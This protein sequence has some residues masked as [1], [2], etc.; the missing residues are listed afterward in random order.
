[1]IY[2]L[3]KRQFLVKTKHFFALFAWL[4]VFHATFVCAADKDAGLQGADHHMQTRNDSR[5]PKVNY[6]TGEHAK[7]AKRGEYLV[8]AG[9]CIACHTDAKRGIKAFAGGEAIKTPFGTLTP[10]NITPDPETGIGKWTDKQFLKALRHGVA[11]DGSFYYPVFPYPYFNKITD[12]D[13]LAIKA[14]LDKVPAVHRK[15]DPSGMHFPFNIR[16]MQLGWRILFYYSNNGVYKPD[17]KQPAAWNRGKYLVDS[18]THCS[19]CHTPI[20]ILGAPKKK[21][22][23]AGSSVTGM[24]APDITSRGLN[25]YTD[26]QIMA[27]F[28]QGKN[29]AGT[30][31]LMGPMKEAETDSFRY[32]S[33]DDLQAIISYLRTVRSKAPP[34]PKLSGSDKGKG[35][36]N[37]YCTGCHTMGAGGAPKYG[38]VAAWSGLLKQGKTVLYDNAIHGLGGMPARGNCASCGDDDIKAAVD[39]IL[40]SVSGESA[41]GGVAKGKAPKRLTM[42]DGKRIY[43]ETTCHLCHQQGQMAAPVLGDK[44]AW[45][46]RIRQ[47]MD[48][49]FNHAI[50]GFGHMPIRGGCV[51]CTD[52]EIIAATKYMVQFSQQGGRYDL[53]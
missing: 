39:Y 52:A 50:H 8:K 44:Q 51:Q 2:L 19:M 22:Y 46:Q 4:V 43:H 6:G 20:N 47:G 34:K 24:Y 12:A 38:S 53:W 10:P 35:I 30:G 37:Q 15:N 21:Y 18:L 45:Y 48:V 32:L 16:F 31:H 9:D 36:Y 26:E 25:A 1:M 14:Y 17:P 40:A 13:A 41:A 28:T 23:L 11:P 49:L 42:A 29:L 33:K 27:V 5:Y 7:Q 3:S